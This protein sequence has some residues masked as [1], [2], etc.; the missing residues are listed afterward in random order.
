M[1]YFELE[2]RVCPFC[3]VQFQP[4][5]RKQITCGSYE[6]KKNRQVYLRRVD[7][8]Q[9][10]DLMMKR[11]K[12]TEAANRARRATKEVDVEWMEYVERYSE[13]FR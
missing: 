2:A 12:Q 4:K 7:E 6:C 13:D 1:S 9:R 3:W 11:K 5:H 8:A 10:A